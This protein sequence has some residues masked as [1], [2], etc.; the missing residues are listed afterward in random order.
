MCAILK[1]IHKHD[2]DKCEFLGTI[3]SLDN[4]G[5]VADLYIHRNQYSKVTSSGGHSI[6]ARY[7]DKGSD[8]TSCPYF[9][10]INFPTGSLDLRVAKK[11]ALKEF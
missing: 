2:C 7:S 6:I 8:Y 3:K 1:P 5:H 4:P 11:I 9:G 10:T